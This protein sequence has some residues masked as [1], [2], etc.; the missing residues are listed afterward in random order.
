MSTVG[1]SRALS[2]VSVSA[3]G[4]LVACGSWS[5]S[6][7]VWWLGDA[8]AEAALAK[9]RNVFS[10]TARVTDVK[11]AAYG[12][13]SPALVTCDA[14]GHISVWDTGSARPL[15]RFRAHSERLSKMALVPFRSNLAVVGSFDSTWSVVDL[16]AEKCFLRQEGHADAV[17]AVAVHPDSSLVLTG[18]FFCVNEH[19]SN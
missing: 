17:Y 2:S 5:G 15:G 9:E 10:A 1:D 3:D 6:A 4:C 7:K 11:F 16:S 8:P 12:G 19:F 13:E 14:A 18:S